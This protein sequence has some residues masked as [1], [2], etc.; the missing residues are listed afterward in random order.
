MQIHAL[1]LGDFFEEESSLFP[2]EIKNTFTLDIKD[3]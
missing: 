2:P 1:G 3:R